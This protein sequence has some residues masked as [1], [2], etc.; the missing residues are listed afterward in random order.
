MTSATGCCRN[1]SGRIKANI[2]N[3]DMACRTGGEEFV[4]VL[5]ATDLDVA[6][7]NRR[8]HAQIGGRQAVQLRRQRAA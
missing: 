4:V 1:W 6:T 8:T 5:P 2:R 3:V 7:E